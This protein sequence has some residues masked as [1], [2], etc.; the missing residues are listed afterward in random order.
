M[1]AFAAKSGKRYAQHPLNATQDYSG[2][3]TT[4]GRS[5]RKVTFTGYPANK[6]VFFAVVACEASSAW[7]GERDDLTPY[8]LSAALSCPRGTSEPSRTWPPCDDA[9]KKTTPA[10]TVNGMAAPAQSRCCRRLSRQS[11]AYY[12]EKKAAT[13]SLSSA[14]GVRGGLRRLHSCVRRGHPSPDVGAPATTRKRKN[15]PAMTVIGMAA[16]AQS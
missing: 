6:A 12:E 10:M 3:S 16:P 4:V 1:V 15:T 8:S 2:G 13:P 7:R 9:K 14:L 11:W 5:G